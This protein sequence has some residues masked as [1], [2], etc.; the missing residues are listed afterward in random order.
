MLSK[1]QIKRILTQCE[2]VKKA[3]DGGNHRLTVPESL[4]QSQARNDGWIQALTLILDG[5]PKSIRNTPLKEKDEQS[6]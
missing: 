3:F 6:V 5:D 1:V 4:K 2:E